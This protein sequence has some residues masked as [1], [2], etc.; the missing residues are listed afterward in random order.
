MTIREKISNFINPKEIPS[1]KKRVILPWADV[2]ESS[3]FS[4]LLNEVPPPWKAEDYL[5][6]CKGWVYACVSAIADEVAT[7]KLHL[8][9][10]KG[11][12]IEEVFKSP[13]LDVLY[14]VNNF[15]TKFD[16]FNLTQR[17]L[18]LTGEAPWLVDKEKDGTP[19]GLYLLRPDKLTIEFDKEKIIGK[20]KYDV[21][22][23]KKEEFEKD[24]VI[25]IKYPNPLKPLRG[26]GTLQ[27]V[28]QTVDLDKYAEEWNTKFFFNS[29]RPDGVLTTE[30]KLTDP[31][32]ELLKKTWNKQFRGIDKHAKLL[33]LE[34]GLKYQQMQMSQKDMDFL[35]QQK[36]SRDKILS[37]FKVPKSIMAISDDVNRASATT[38]SYVFERWTIKP[39]MTRIIEQLNE[40]FLPM[41]NGTEN[42]FLDFD[43]P[44]PQ[45]VEAKLKKY[46]NALKNG[47]MTPNEVRDAEQ[48]ESIEGGDTIYIPANLIPMGSVEVEE[49]TEEPGEE[50]EKPEEEKKSDKYHDTLLSLNAR[51]KGKKVDEKVIKDTIKAVVRAHLIKAKND[52]PKK[53]IE[54]K[55]K[56]I[57]DKE[58][59]WRKQIV[60]QERYE[61]QMI[62]KLKDLFSSQEKEVLAKL[63]QKDEIARTKAFNKQDNTGNTYLHEMKIDIVSVLLSLKKETRRFGL[64]LT[65]ILRGTVKDEGDY[66]LNEMNIDET[67]V[68]TEAVE[69]HLKKSKFFGE[70]N[71]VTNKKLRKTLAEGIAEGE[72][73][74]KLRNRISG[75]FT[76]ADKVRTNVIARTETSR[77]MNYGTTKAYKQSGVV[78]AQEWLT[79][80]DSRTC[81]W[82]ADLD[83]KIVA[84]DENYFNQGD[85][86]TVD[87]N[88]LN[89]DYEDVG[90]PPLHA[91][92]L[93]DAQIP[94]LTSKGWNRIKD[95]KVNDLVLTHSG[96][97]KKVTKLL[98]KQN[99]DG[100]VFK[101]IYGWENHK[102][103]ITKQSITFTPEHPLLTERGW[104]LAKDIRKDDKLIFKA[105]ECKKCGKLFPHFATH[106][107]IDFCSKSCSSKY[108]AEI[109]FKNEE[110][111][112]MSLPII[113]IK[114]WKLKKKRR[115]YNFAV[116]DDE[117]Y[118]AKGMVTHNCRCTTIPVLKEL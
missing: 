49:G 25:L 59:F 86:Y 32:R 63:G 2:P 22:G 102:G 43:D 44:V 16:H 11:E 89:L 28:V 23:G 66:V 114:K 88:T 39:K 62:A 27:A 42:Q 76:Q 69:T 116:A 40:F 29:A 90:F 87:G 74:P 94:I 115:I 83:G 45:D 117:S 79:S 17:Y 50:V 108:T 55:P 91:L 57:K 52:K 24:Q 105:K 71:K 31:Q 92:C 26:I 75:V 109:Q 8:Y 20:Y 99:Y 84:L 110:Y 64:V 101:F 82:C 47:W 46:E 36:F 37:I 61:K 51:R 9:E 73:I 5:K 7:I 103:I 104:I 107:N 12:E 19:I 35:A 53:K 106:E 111:K 18:E 21:G 15:T 10:R 78:E 41:F 93:I 70:V 65:P 81:S 67:F 58:K 56:Q 33:I 13:I 95:I 14:K 80:F 68:M 6:E 1:K 60:I 77:A 4:P 113:E 38:H 98:E 30:G 34:A 118:I 100:D 54:K 48:L 72:G 96:K 112:F 3:Y 97:F 85:E